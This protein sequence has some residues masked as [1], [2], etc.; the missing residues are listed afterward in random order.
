MVVAGVE[1]W[2]VTK[3]SFSSLIQ[4][5]RSSLVGSD[6]VGRCENVIGG[7]VGVRAQRSLFQMVGHSGF[8]THLFIPVCGVLNYPRGPKLFYGVCE[9]KKEFPGV[10]WGYPTEG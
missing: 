4:L 10:C 8:L 7:P 2:W 5:A 1:R 6:S 3:Y 9:L